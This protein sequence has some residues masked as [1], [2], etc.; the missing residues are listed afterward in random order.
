[1][2]STGINLNWKW[3]RIEYHILRIVSSL[4]MYIMLCIAWK[5]LWLD[6]IFCY[7]CCNLHRFLLVAI[8]VISLA[9]SRLCPLLVSPFASSFA[10]T[11]FVSF[12]ARFNPQTKYHYSLLE[13]STSFELVVCL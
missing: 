11:G 10:V 6:T 5:Q 4:T 7:F 9:V 1:L 2:G 8:N 3:V 12:D 13:I